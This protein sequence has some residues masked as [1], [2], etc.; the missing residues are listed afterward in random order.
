MTTRLLGELVELQRGTTY[1]S[2]LLGIPGPVLLGLAS[3]ARDGGF[4]DDSLRTY[5]GESPEKLLLTPG[6]LYV[7]LKDVTQSGDLLGSVA[8]VPPTVAI[9]RLT[10]DTVKLVLR[11][12]APRAGFIYWLL[13]TPEYR[14]YC[15]ARA[16]GTTNLSLSREDFLAFPVPQ[17]TAT[18]IRLVDLLDA[19][20]TKI[21]LN[22]R[23]T[24]TM[25][26][27]ARALFKSLFVDFD[28]ADGEMPDGWSV[29]TLAS[30]C[31][32]AG[33]E[34]QT[35]P[36][37][38][39][40][41]A[42]DY[43]DNG[44]P[45]VMPTNIRDRRVLADRIA[46]TSAANVERLDRHRLLRGD[47]VYSRRGDVEKHAIVGQEEE[48]WLCGTGCLRVRPSRAGQRGMSSHYLSLWLD[49]PEQRAWISARAIGATM[50]NLNTKILGE[51][52]VVLPDS[53][54][55][56]TF[57]GFMEPL[58]ARIR[59]LRAESRTLAELRDL[60]LPKLLSGELRIRDAECAIEAVA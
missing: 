44:V 33:G 24:E 6:D 25:E 53:E 35:G 17:P 23:T 2:A 45:V 58:D 3:I 55:L 20:E 31:T 11:S 40:L 30:I 34:V 18:D 19:L 14:A 29:D 43:T 28:R 42:S 1:K 27:I 7:S 41:H 56:A 52:P 38:S 36:F 60:L 49:Q 5:G 10:Q 21:D 46:R 22:R 39:Q 32:A 12:G 37:G 9:G 47:L 16:I 8:R 4:R 59:A 54:T 51:V 13:R 57:D 15:R 50:P 26:E 48:G